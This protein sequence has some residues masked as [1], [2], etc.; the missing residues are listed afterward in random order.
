M[1]LNVSKQLLHIGDTESHDACWE[2]QQQK[3][4]FKKKEVSGV[5]FKVVPVP[6]RPK[7]SDLT[8]RLEVLY[9]VLDTRGL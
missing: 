4:E 2:K 7:N 5:R 8:M 9:S 6:L 3:F 1:D